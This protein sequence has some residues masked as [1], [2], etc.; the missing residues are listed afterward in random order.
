MN[1]LTVADRNI[2]FYVFVKIFAKR[3]FLPLTAIY[4]IETAGFT[5]RDIGILSGY[6]SLVQLL[7]EIPT[8]YFADK[9]GR[10]A[11]IRVGAI[12]AAIATFFYVIFHFKTGIY[13]GVFFEALGYSFMAGAGEALIHDS[14]VVKKQVN[15]YTK[16]L[17]HTM[18]ISL[19]A[20]AILIALVPMTY[21]IYKGLPFI[22]G[23][24]CYIA[25]FIATLFMNDVTRSESNVK[26]KMPDFRKI[27]GKRH[28]LL[29]GLTFGI[30]S[31]LYTSPNDIYNLALREYGF[32]I[33]LIGWVYGIAS[34]LGAAIGPFIHHLRNL[35]LS[36]YLI[37]DLTMLFAVY[38]A[39]FSQ[40]PYFLS[41]AMIVGISFWRY[42][43]IIYQDYLLTIYPT[44]YKATLISG[45]NN[46]EELNSVWLPLAITYAIYRTSI[47]T[48]L[49]LVAIFI[50]TIAPIFFF[51]TRRFFR[52]D[53]LPLTLAKLPVSIV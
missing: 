4:F 32:R 24:I 10:V 23:T 43:R 3:V 13:A 21:P 28:L 49:G 35:R 1:Q 14:L 48:G 15:Q 30:V 26:L 25:L 19:I 42:R 8:G 12:L 36:R 34:I 27:A 31:A 16:I 9:I 53:P 38:L 29:F 18:S 7:A 41:L 17:S 33:D 52:R 40:N 20:N 37:I 22:I 44:Q 2:K 50:L 51:S 47:S 39:G 46:L 45:M 5:I 6:F 11:S